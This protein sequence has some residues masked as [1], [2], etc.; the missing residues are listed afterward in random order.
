[1]VKA[2]PKVAKKRVGSTT[3]KTRAVIVDAAG[4]LMLDEG[5]AAITFRSVASQAGVATGLVQ[6]YFPSLDDL[7]LALI[8]QGTDHAVETVRAAAD[9]AQPLRLIWKYANNADAARML[10][11]YMALANHRKVI[12]DELGKGGE[13][14]RRAQLDAIK[15]PWKRYKPEGLALTP[16]AFVFMLNSLPRMALLEQHY[17]TTTGHADTKRLIEKFLDTVE[18]KKVVKR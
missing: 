13:E 16:E 12:A 18:P 4:A 14:V 1:M 17:G 15:P 11:E 8:R 6:Y 9:S 3:S 5:Y 2:E 7:F 10:M